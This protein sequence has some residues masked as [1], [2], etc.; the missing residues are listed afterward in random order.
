MTEGL[1]IY[2]YYHRHVFTNVYIHFHLCSRVKV[3]RIGTE[4]FKVRPV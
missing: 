3:S 2:K 1:H 4:E